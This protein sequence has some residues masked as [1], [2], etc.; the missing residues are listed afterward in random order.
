MTGA[1]W[2]P[3]VADGFSS[4]V[5]VGASTESTVALSAATSGAMRVLI[6]GVP[7]KLPAG[8]WGYRADASHTLLGGALNDVGRAIS[9][10]TS[11]LQISPE[12]DLNELLLAHPDPVTPLVL[13]F[14]SGERSTGWAADARTIFSG[15][16]AATTAAMVFRGT[17]E[18]VAISYA[19][20]A[21]QLHDV[22]G[23]TR[24]VG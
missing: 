21:D 6:E 3:P 4:N 17:V 14:F 16:S 11:T 23:E 1:L 2:F 15:V 19:R 9:W 12:S 24:Q 18:G 20:I 22:A 5:G 13:P 7:E 10:L 8:L